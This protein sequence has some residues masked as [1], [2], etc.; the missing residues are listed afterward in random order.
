MKTVNTHEA[1]THLS[2]LLDE[3][4]AGEEIVIAKAGVPVA[5]LVRYE[6]AREARMLGLLRGKIVETSD[7]WE[8]DPEMAASIAAPLFPDSGM[9]PAMKV[10]EEP[11]A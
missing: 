3:A 1:K 6:S 2:R 4:A 5:K 9:I 10:A 7:C 11:G 8:S